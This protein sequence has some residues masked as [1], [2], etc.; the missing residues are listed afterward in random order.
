MTRPSIALLALATTAA[1]TPDGLPTGTLVMVA[2][3]I[4]GVL[5][6]RGV[7]LRRRLR[8]RSARRGHD[9][10]TVAGSE[11]G[12]QSDRER[13]GDDWSDADGGGGD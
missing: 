2:L 11:A 10:A 4:A 1:T 3:A 6:A 13:G 7:M 12:G 8:K 9:D 5:V